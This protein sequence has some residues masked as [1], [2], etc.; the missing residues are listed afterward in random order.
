MELSLYFIGHAYISRR[1]EAL[2]RFSL[3]KVCV[4]SYQGVVKGGQGG[5]LDNWNNE[6]K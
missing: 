1:Q 2:K 5:L 3:K 6:M 4:V